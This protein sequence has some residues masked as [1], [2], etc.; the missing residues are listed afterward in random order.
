MR[1]QPNSCQSRPHSLP[2]MIKFL[3]VATGV[4]VFGPVNGPVCPSP[5]VDSKN[6]FQQ[7]KTVAILC[8][9]FCLQ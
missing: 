1:R 7:S 5:Q 4:K 3:V 8:V 2:L 9:S 6:I